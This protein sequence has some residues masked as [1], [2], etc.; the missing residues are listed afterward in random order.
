MPSRQEAP[1]LLRSSSSDALIVV[2]VRQAAATGA[3]TGVA[4]SHHNREGERQP[5][6]HH[7]LE[8]R[9]YGHLQR[10][11]HRGFATDRGVVLVDTKLPGWGQPS[12]IGSK[13]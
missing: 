9:Q 3:D 5:V 10:R 4:E 6:C 2:L 13:R 8:R 7:R 1:S 12:F 11:Q